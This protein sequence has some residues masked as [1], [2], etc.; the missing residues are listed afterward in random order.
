M[1]QPKRINTASWEAYHPTGEHPGQEALKG[2]L[3]TPKS[4]PSKFFYDDEGS[5]LFDR[6]CETPEYYVTRT[7]LRLLEQVAGEIAAATKS[8][9]L[10]EL[11]SGMARKSHLLLEALS[12]RNKN[13][14]LRY[15]PLDISES[16]LEIACRN[17]GRDFPQVGLQPIVCDYT[18]DL[19]ALGRGGRR[20]M[21]FLGS[22]IGNFP[23]AEAGRMLKNWGRCMEADDWFLLGVDLV[24]SKAV[25]EAAYNDA[26]G[27]TEAFNRN[28]LA[29]A[30][31]LL[32][33]DFNPEAFA[34]LAFYNGEQRRIEMHLVA[35][36]PMEVRLGASGKVIRFDENERLMTEI[37]R[38]FTRVTVEKLL[39]RSGFAM[40]HWYESEDRYFALA[41]ARKT[42]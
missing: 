28:I 6:I 33:A 18:S 17:V 7:E 1:W 4:L 3:S 10:L 37:S 29:V 36:Q 24:K 19:G 23:D 41:L 27:V 21:A 39:A 9:E 30:N 14:E 31:R 13:E 38:K 12:E 16:A 11:G 25:L 2:L 8:A 35:G 32:D 5:R 40:R 26:E 34:H 15:T 22:T 20:L 42:V